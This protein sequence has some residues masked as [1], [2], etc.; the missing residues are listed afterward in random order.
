MA[1]KTAL[2]SLD[3][4]IAE[5][6]TSPFANPCGNEFCTCGATCTCGPGCKCGVPAPPVPA[7]K[8]GEK[9]KKEKKAAAPPVSAEDLDINAID[10]RVGMYMSC[11]GLVYVLFMS[12]ILY[13]DKAS[14]GRFLN[15]RLPTSSIAKR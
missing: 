8:A 10:L 15:T 14:F 3:S 11:I 6:E 7:P 9:A 5:F 12:Y 13:N 4:L 1:K 2:E